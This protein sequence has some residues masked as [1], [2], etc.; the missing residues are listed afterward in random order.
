MLVIAE[1]KSLQQKIKSLKNGAT[2]GFVPTMGALHEGHLSLVEMAKKRERYCGCEHI[3][4]P[5]SV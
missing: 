1:I 3:C 4:E 5:N 2:I